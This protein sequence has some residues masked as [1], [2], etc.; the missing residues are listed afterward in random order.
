MWKAV[1]K[2]FEVVGNGLAWRVGSGHL[3]RIGLDPWAGCYRQHLLNADL[4][5]WLESMGV[6]SIWHKSGT[7]TLQISGVKV[8]KVEE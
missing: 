4:R 5:S 2:A 3:F 8:G 6:T 1:H 7:Q